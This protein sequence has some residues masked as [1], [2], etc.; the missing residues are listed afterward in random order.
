MVDIQTIHSYL[1][2]VEPSPL[3]SE[4]S[5]ECLY[6]LLPPGIRSCIRA[7]YILRKWII[8]KLV[9]PRIGLRAR[10]ARMESLIQALEV[11]RMRSLEHNTRL[12]DQPCVRSFVEAV[13]SSALISS[14]SRMHHRAWQNV[15]VNRGSQCDSLASLLSRPTVRSVSSNEPLTV[16]MGWLIERILDVVAMPDTV[17]PIHQEGQSLV[18][19]DKRRSVLSTPYL[20]NCN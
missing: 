16:D 7:F 17:E 1:Q 11:S 13:I 18:N 12:D 20:T 2:E 9:A 6:R 8:S 19:F 15:A 3:I 4:L 10:Q 5:P 14:E